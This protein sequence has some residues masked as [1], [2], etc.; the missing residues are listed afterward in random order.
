MTNHP[1][2][3]I[4]GVSPAEVPDSNEAPFE[5]RIPRLLFTAGEAAER[6]SIS[7]KTFTRA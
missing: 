5:R 6:L 1:P 7:Q 4:D 2:N 3:S